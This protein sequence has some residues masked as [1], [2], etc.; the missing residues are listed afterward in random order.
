MGTL[1]LLAYM[2]IPAIMFLIFCLTPNGK[3]WLKQNNLL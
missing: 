1:F 2:G 3:Q